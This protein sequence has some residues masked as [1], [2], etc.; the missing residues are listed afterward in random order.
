VRDMVEVASFVMDTMDALL[1]WDDKSI[2][3]GQVKEDWR[4]PDL[5]W[6]FVENG[7][8]PVRSLKPWPQCRHR[9]LR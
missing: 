5:T 9:N 7:G 8:V 3:D 1:Q 6:H 2:V 4:V